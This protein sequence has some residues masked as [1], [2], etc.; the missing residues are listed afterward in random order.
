MTPTRLRPGQN[1][2]S[3]GIYL[4][5]RELVLLG[6]AMLADGTRLGTQGSAVDVG[7]GEVHIIL[8]PVDVTGSLIYVPDPLGT[9]V[10]MQ[11]TRQARVARSAVDK[12]T[13]D[14][15][16]SVS[17]SFMN[18]TENLPS[19]ILGSPGD[20]FL[21]GGGANDTIDAGAG[22]DAVGGGRG[23]D[24][25]TLGPGADYTLLGLGKDTVTADGQD[26]VLDAT[27]EDTV[28]RDAT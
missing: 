23:D 12:M 5:G 25:I 7:N 8:D 4:R 27:G 13:V 3:P 16:G 2:T 21:L 17:A 10:P 20:D 22:N 19:Q 11:V 26:T 1:P 24:S 18:L 14:L 9:D 28:R 6:W 15:R